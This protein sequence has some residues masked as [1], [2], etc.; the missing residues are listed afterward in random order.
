MLLKKK[1]PLRYILGKIKFELAI[2]LVYTCLFDAFHRFNPELNT[3]IP[4][5]IPS[6]IGTVI[7]LLLAFK[8]NQAYDRWWEA[9]IIWGAITNDSRTLIRQM[10]TFYK[11]PAFSMEANNFIEKMAKRQAAW[12]YSLGNALRGENVYKPIQGLLSAEEFD[13]VKRHKHVPN[14][15]LILH[16]K[17]LKDA[18]QGEKINAFQQIQMDTTLTQFCDHM[19]KCERIKTTVFPTTYG[20]YI[21][22]TIYL[23]IMMLP[24]SLPTM[25]RTLE[26]PLVTIIAAAFFLVEK[27]AI[28]LQDPFENKPTDTPVSTIAK[29]IEK[30]LMQMVNEYN[31]EFLN[32]SE[33][34]ESNMHPKK[35]IQKMEDYYIL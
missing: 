27:M 30:N 28:H 10:M 25:L 13:Y 21:H 16:G 9:R 3:E 4:L 6:V 17:D 32:K 2:V 35:V 14:A 34:F 19:G 26:I 15:L 24:F 5:A 1:I 8:S 33:H 20:L 12:C 29:N 7:S 31:D 11:D 18:L 22:M 23:F